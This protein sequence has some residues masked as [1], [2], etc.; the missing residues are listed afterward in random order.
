M[1]KLEIMTGTLVTLAISWEVVPLWFSYL[2]PT[3]LTQLGKEPMI[4][5]EILLTKSSHH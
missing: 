3:L 2:S 1:E 5:M 4:A